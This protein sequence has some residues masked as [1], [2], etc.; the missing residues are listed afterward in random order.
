MSSTKLRTSSKST[1]PAL[2]IARASAAKVSAREADIA[3][4][5]L[6]R[7]EVKMMLEVCS[8]LRGV[9]PTR[10]NLSHVTPQHLR[11]LERVGGPVHDGDLRAGAS[12]P[13]SQGKRPELIGGGLGHDAIV[14]PTSDPSQAS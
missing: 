7:F 14:A 11:E 3:D 1:D 9:G 5:L 13:I 8:T 6:Q 10:V 12:S 2:A 4:A